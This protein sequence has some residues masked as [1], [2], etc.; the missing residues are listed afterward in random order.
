[1]PV[2]RT[3]KRT[4]KRHHRKAKSKRRYAKN[5]DT[6]TMLLIGGAIAALGVAG[7]FL[8]RKPEDKAEQGKKN[9]KSALEAA[10]TLAQR[11]ATYHKGLYE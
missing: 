2:R 8:L 11:Q 10:K 1:M 4:A 6:Q 9:Y 7:Y 3:K 5:P